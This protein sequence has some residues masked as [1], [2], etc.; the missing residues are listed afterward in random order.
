LEL[1]TRALPPDQDR[2]FFSLIDQS[3]GAVDSHIELV[4]YYQRENLPMQFV[5]PAEAGGMEIN[6]VEESS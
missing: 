5:F 3:A 2:I 1:A 6:H 4:N